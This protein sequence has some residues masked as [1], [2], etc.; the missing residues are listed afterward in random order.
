MH[1]V[2]FRKLVT[3]E[4]HNED[5]FFRSKAKSTLNEPK[6]KFKY[7]PKSQTRH[8]ASEIKDDEKTAYNRV[9]EIS[10]ANI[11]SKSEDNI[12]SYDDILKSK[13]ETVPPDS[14]S[15][16]ANNSNTSVA[17]TINSMDVEAASR[18]ESGIKGRSDGYIDEQYT[19]LTGSQY[20]GTLIPKPPATAP[21]TIVYADP[22]L[23]DAVVNT[24]SGRSIIDKRRTLGKSTPNIRPQ[25]TRS[26]VK[27][28]LEQTTDKSF[29][30]ITSTIKTPDKQIIQT[31]KKKKAPPLNKSSDLPEK[32]KSSSDLLHVSGGNA[33]SMKQNLFIDLAINEDEKEKSLK[34]IQSSSTRFAVNIPTGRE[35]DIGS[36]AD[37]CCLRTEAIKR[38]TSSRQAKQT[39]M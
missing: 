13:T 3:E 4:L 9:S 32:P 11:I 23:E 5:I 38:I 12:V 24:R 30:Q 29:I 19:F 36:Q 37:Q 7:R 21:S 35:G 16:L 6:L 33:K 15:K 34:E 14:R 8:E 22:D 20:Y 26:S 27:G 18:P 2:I 28:S 1:P 39:Y 31:L 10:F 25:I 17:F